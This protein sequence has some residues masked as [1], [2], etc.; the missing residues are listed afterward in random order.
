[1]TAVVPNPLIAALLVV[2]VLYVRVAWWGTP[3]FGEHFPWIAA[4][5]AT[6]I[7]AVVA[8][9]TRGS[10]SANELLFTRPSQAWLEA[11]LLT[12]LVT[13][14]VFGASARSVLSRQRRNP[15]GPT[16]WDWIASVLAGIVGLL[17]IVTLVIV[18]G[19][20]VWR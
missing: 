5:G 4:L 15:T 8:A 7:V 14:P 9:L 1:M 6:A 18:L 11:A 13:L 2:M 20:L 3:R 19:I 16:A 12:T 10:A 17:F